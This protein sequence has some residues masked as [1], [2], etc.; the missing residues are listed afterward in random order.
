VAAHGI[1]IAFR[2]GLFR[3]F[4]NCN[5]EDFR[6]IADR[7][8]LSVRDRGLNKDALSVVRIARQLLGAAMLMVTGRAGTEAVRSDSDRRFIPTNKSDLWNRQLRGPR[9]GV[10]YWTVAAC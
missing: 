6:N 3:T 1:K 4:I 10:R 5:V 7:C 2:L 9:R 8:Q